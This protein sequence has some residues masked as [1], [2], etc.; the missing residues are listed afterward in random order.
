VRTTRQ[1]IGV[2]VDA[3]AQA[4]QGED[5]VS[6]VERLA[7]E[8]GPEGHPLLQ[9]ILL[10]RAARE[11]SF[12]RALRRRFEAKGWTSRTLAR[13]ESLWREDRAEAVVVAIEA[14]PEGET[15]LRQELEMMRKDSGRAAVVLDELSRHRDRRVRAWV[16]GAAADVLGDGATRLILSLARN[17][18]AAVREAAVSALLRLGPAAAHAVLPDLR[19][20]LHSKEPAERIAAMQNLAAAG[21]GSVLVLL[22]ERAATA[23]LPE[24]RDAAR[25]AA[26]ALR[27]GGAGSNDLE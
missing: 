15:R 16:P 11:E 22:D 6:A 13:F 1:E 5:F 10:E 19:R 18:D 24:E 25:A 2:R 21:D 3:L 23:A 12:Q 17:R 4:H 27:S 20:R 9:E 26:V 14:G 7:E 8:L